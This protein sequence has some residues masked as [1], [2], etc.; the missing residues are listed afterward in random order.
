MYDLRYGVVAP[1]PDDEVIGCFTLLRTG[2]VVYVVYPSEYRGFEESIRRMSE[3]YG[4]EA[5]FGIGSKSLPKVDV[6]LVPDPTESH[7]M[8]RYAYALTRRRLFRYD[9]VGYYTTEMD[10]PYTAVLPRWLAEAKRNVLDTHYAIKSDMW[11][12]EH[13]YWLFEGIAISLLR[14][15]GG[16]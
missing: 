4:F 15:W 1:H 14:P 13:K 9:F 10:A 2:S 3:E 11:R 5:R 6:L 7:P 8:H 16:G 12:Y